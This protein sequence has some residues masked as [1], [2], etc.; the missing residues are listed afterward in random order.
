MLKLRRILTAVICLTASVITS[1]GQV[2]WKI[3]GNG[4][5]RPSYV[6]GTMH[7]ASQS[8]VN[9]VPGVREAVDSTSQVYGEIVFDDVAN[10]DTIKAM[11]QKMSLPGNKTIKD[12]LSAAQMLKL[13]A[14]VKRLIG[15]D[16]NNPKMM[17]QMGHQT[18]ATLA[19]NLNGMLFLTRHMG[20][21][22]PL[23]GI[24]NYFQAQAKANN[25]Y[26]GGLETV[27]FQTDLLYNSVSLE[28][29]IT[30]LLCLID[31]E[32]FYVDIN[33]RM[34]KTY[35]EQNLDSLSTLMDEKMGNSCDDTPE[36]KSRFVYDRNSKWLDKMPAIM[37]ATPTLFVVGAGHLPG[38]KGL[39]Q[40][41]RKKGYTIKAVY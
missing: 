17:E 35:Y 34:V 1:D 23:H 9:S 13:N 20:E 7:F 28:R 21:F 4:L 27:A 12:V 15:T 11:K 8:F 39:L 26:I 40:G 29:G 16:F 2:L 37:E 36:E 25:E 3:S 6:F 14:F 5:S 38:D 33:E 41:L 31:H 19:S 10:A 24:D 32:D 18:P 30:Q 22:D